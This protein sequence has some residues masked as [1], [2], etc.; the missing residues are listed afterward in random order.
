MISADQPLITVP[1]HPVTTDHP[2][3]AD[4]TVDTPLINAGHDG[5]QCYRRG[6]DL[7]L[8]FDFEDVQQ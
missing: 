6:H 8:I 7:V 4:R 2:I 1:D 5:G 3:T